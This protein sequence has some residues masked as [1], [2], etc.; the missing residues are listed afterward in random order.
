VSS[1]LINVVVCVQH[2]G[3]LLCIRSRASNEHF[4]MF[5]LGTVSVSM[6]G[7]GLWAY[8]KGKCGC[9]GIIRKHFDMCIFC[10]K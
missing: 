5:S 4:W 7:S 10:R 6:A 1:I 3:M 9:V 8:S 2:G